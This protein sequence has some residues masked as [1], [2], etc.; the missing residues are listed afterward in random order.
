MFGKKN[1]GGFMDVIRCDEQSYLV[2]KWRPGGQA[3]NTT[4]KENA[5]RFGSSLRVKDGE[6]AVFVY[7]QK[8]GTTMDFI[9]GPHDKKIETA[10]FP[11]LSSIVG[12]AF[13]GSS[14]FQAEIYFINLAGTIRIRFGI[15]AFDVFDPRFL[16]FAVPMAVRGEVVFNI[17]DYKAFIKMHRLTDFDLER[18][19]EEARVSLSRHVKTVVTN[20]PDQAGIPVIQMEK[21]LD[22][23]SEFVKMRLM[24]T[25]SETLAVGVKEVN[26]EAIEPDK[27]SEGWK[28]LRK[29]TANLTMKTTEAQAGVNIQ[30][31][32]DM[33]RI[34]AENMQD[35]MRIQREE[36]QFAQRAQTEEAQFAQ[37]AQTTEAQH[38]QRMQTD[39]QNF[40][41]HQL[42]QQT[43][44]A[45]AGADALGKMGAGGAMNMGGG[46]MNPAGMM[47]G[48]MMGGAVGGQMAGMMGNMMQGVNQPAQQPGMP[49]M[50]SMPS[51]PGM[52][53]PPPGGMAP[54]PPAAVSY[55]V[56]VNGQTMGPYDMN[57]LAQMVQSGQLTPESQVWKQGMAGWVAAGTVQELSG[58]FAQSAPPPPPPPAP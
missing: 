53:P 27:E 3:A 50:P 15:P 14:P 12:A 41:L 2:W 56:A 33:Q 42:N 37:R 24:T 19:R 29:V 43:K 20:V 10:N 47:T 40:A 25:M 13:G 26:I 51:A 39:S 36:A 57:A 38:A 32:Q 5:I 9:E 8:D 16:D 11:I 34:N 58:L 1:E 31:M 17:P 45:L 52:A 23:I 35:T 7:S 46:G 49:G 28:E 18:F 44:V 55:S 48:M 54:P 21:M 30:N 6:V 4:K 22:N